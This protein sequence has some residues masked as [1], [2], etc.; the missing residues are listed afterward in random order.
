LKLQMKLV[1]LAG[2][3]ALAAVPA[4]AVADVPTDNPGNVPENPGSSLK[5]TNPGPKAS[6]PTKAKAYGFHCQGTDKKKDPGETGKTDFAKCVTDMARLAVGSADS[7]K[8]ACSN[9]SKKHVKG[10]KRTPY[11][12]CV[13]GGSDL[14]QDLQDQSQQGTTS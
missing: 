2:T 9:L 13:S 3:L 12:V 1:V 11:A 8:Q 14:L 10:E 5:P 7:P 6:V 4:L